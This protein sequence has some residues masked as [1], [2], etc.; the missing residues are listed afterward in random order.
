LPD[1]RLRHRHPSRPSRTRARP[2]Y[3]GLHHFAWNADSRQDVDRLHGRLVEAGV[4]ILDA[5]AEYPQYGAG[6]YAV[7]F[8]D[9]TVSSSSSSITPDDRWCANLSGLAIRTVLFSSFHPLA[10]GRRAGAPCHSG[11]R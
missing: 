4:P 10:A 5:P 9:P 7:F 1:G 3:D 8:A 11:G 2:L 6:Y